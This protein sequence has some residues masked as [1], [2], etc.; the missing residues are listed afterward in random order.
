MIPE[1]DPKALKPTDILIVDDEEGALE[2]LCF[3]LRQ[4]GYSVA[5][6]ASGE[7]TLDLIA[8]HSFR[9]VLLDLVMPDLDGIQ[10][11]RH[12]RELHPATPVILMTGYY[13]DEIKRQVEEDPQVQILYKPLDV[14]QV[15][16]LCETAT[17]QA[18][19]P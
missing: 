16:A 4:K 7:K 9:L 11:W 19:G 1:H 10:L 15:L 3:I 8:R 14:P 2:T 17:S 13:S 6:A 5:V 18:V 12:F